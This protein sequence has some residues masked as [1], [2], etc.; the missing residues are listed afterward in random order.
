MCI[1]IKCYFRHYLIEMQISRVASDVGYHFFARGSN[2]VRYL[3]CL[4][5]SMSKRK[6]FS[7]MRL[8][9][10][11]QNICKVLYLQNKF[12][13]SLYYSPTHER[14]CWMNRNIFF[15]ERVVFV[16]RVQ[17]LFFSSPWSSWGRP[18]NQIRV[19]HRHWIHHSKSGLSFFI[20]MVHQDRSVSES[21]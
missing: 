6:H 15:S 20:N 7:N 1:S 21:R 10:V 14:A 18:T 8:Y 16:W 19:A 17:S 12:I 5:F 9:V 11:S 3:F 13:Q 2:L 4:F